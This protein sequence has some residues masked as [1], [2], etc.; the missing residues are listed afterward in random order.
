MLFSVVR[1]T[2]VWMPM[3]GT[4]AF[5]IAQVQKLAIYWYDPE[6]QNKPFLQ[7]FDMNFTE[8]VQC[9]WMHLSKSKMRLTP[10]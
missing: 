9:C 3:S 1:K 5:S 7:T 2:T 4:R 6:K 10:P 8:Q